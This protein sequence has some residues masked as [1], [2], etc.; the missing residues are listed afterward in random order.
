MIE[1]GATLGFSKGNNVGIRNAQ[2]EYVLILNPDTIVHPGALQKWIEFADRH[3]EAGSFGCRVL[4]ADGSYQ[5]SPRPFPTLWRN[6]VAALYMRP[7][8][9]FS[10]AFVSDTY[11]GWKGDTERQIDWQCRL[12]R[13]V[14]WDTAQATERL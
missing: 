8:A 13:Y 6:W 4:N 2:G 12:L 7:L 3:A 10:D 9:R 14:S 11:I 1:N 5:G